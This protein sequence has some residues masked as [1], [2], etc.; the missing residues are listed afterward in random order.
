MTNL[1]IYAVIVLILFFTRKYW[2]LFIV[3]LFKKSKRVKVNLIEN[4]EIF[5]PAGTVRSFNITLLIT[6]KGDGTVEI[7]I[8]KQKQKNEAD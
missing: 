4:S 8:G 6:E 1:I 3:S 5:A 7:T 2:A